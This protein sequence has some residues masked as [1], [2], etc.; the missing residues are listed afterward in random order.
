MVGSVLLVE[1]NWKLDRKF[2]QQYVTEKWEETLP[3]TV[4]GI[5]KYLGSGLIKGVGP[6]F[7]KRIVTVFGANTLQ[8]IEDTADRLSEVPGI[9]KKRIEMIRRG[10]EQ[11]KEIKNIMLFLQGHDVS[12]AHAARIYKTYGNE[13]IQKIKENP[14]R[15]ADDIWGIGFKTADQIAA[16][17][18]FGTDDFVRCR[19]GLLYT[20]NQLAEEGHTFAGQEQL[21][22]AASKLLGVEEQP[23]AGSLDKILQSDDLI[24]DGD[25]IYLPAF[26][27]SEVGAAST[28]LRTSSF[29]SLLMISSFSCTIFSQHVCS[30]S[31]R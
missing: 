14:Y 5:E 9:G 29:S 11:Q 7:A 20:L 18:G 15:L 6:K 26:Y 25:A 28:L 31:F 2:G 17:L 21:I 10:W 16:K 4:Y 1:G 12:T 19:S 23:I 13:S 3:A 27:Y 30:F 24:L 22:K 8:V